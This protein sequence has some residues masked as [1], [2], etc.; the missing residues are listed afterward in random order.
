MPYA[1]A[2]RQPATAAPKADA[3]AAPDE[4]ASWVGDAQ[5]GYR[6]ALKKLYDAYKNSVFQTALLLLSSREAAAT[7]TEEVFVRFSEGEQ[8][9]GHAFELWL[10]RT[11]SQVCTMHMAGEEG[12]PANPRLPVDEPDRA[13]AIRRRIA[14]ALATLDPDVRVAFVL[15][16]GQGFD[17]DGIARVMG[18]TEDDVARHLAAARSRIAAV[19]EGIEFE[20]WNVG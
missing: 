13:T 10:Y 14:G 3:S 16:E 19:L 12:V 8:V 5:N 20:A 11:I 2:R 6:D 1:D 17:Y 15:R 7:V 9:D 4:V 18:G